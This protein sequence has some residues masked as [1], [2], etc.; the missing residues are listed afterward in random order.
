MKK[1]L[2]ATALSALCAAGAMAEDKVAITVNAVQ[3]F[4]TIDPSKVN[5]YTEYMAAVNLYDALTTVNAE[6]AVIPQL[7]E[8]WDIS[9][10]SLTYTFH[11]KEGAMYRT[12]PR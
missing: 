7:A 9:E 5:D 4:G 12:A 2:T 6:G 3:I 11:L 8:S 10:D 1:L